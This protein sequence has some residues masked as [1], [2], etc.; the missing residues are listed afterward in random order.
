MEIVNQ[1]T[2]ELFNFYNG[3]SSWESSVIKASDLT[4]S[5]AH[6]IEVLGQHG[7]MNMKQLA[8][9]LGVTT[10]ATTFA[11]DRLEN[12]NYAARNST[13]EDRR[14]YYISLT[15]KGMLVYND[16][17]QSH[18]EL[19]KKM[20]SVLSEEESEQF[21]KITQKINSAVFG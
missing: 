16:H 1:L 8:E 9:K 13:K 21:L 14:V 5:E 2:D 15:E 10:G 18:Q 19:S 6:T 11:V 12:K 17:H 7:Q 4:V 20:L 3:F